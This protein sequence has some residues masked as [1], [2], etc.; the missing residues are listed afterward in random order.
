MRSFSQETNAIAGGD[1]DGAAFPIVGPEDAAS[2]ESPTAPTFCCCDVRTPVVDGGARFCG[3]NSSVWMLLNKL[4]RCG[5]TDVVSELRPRM[6]SN[7]LSE[8][9]KKR[10][11]ATRFV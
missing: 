1:R 7:S 6:S 4:R 2:A 9:K 3:A 8:M 10:G 11:Y 5:T